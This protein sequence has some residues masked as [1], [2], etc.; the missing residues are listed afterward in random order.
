MSDFQVPGSV[1]IPD[2]DDCTFFVPREAKDHIPDN[3]GAR[4]FTVS[5]IIVSSGV[6]GGGPGRWEHRQ[7]T[8]NATCYGAGVEKFPSPVN[9]SWGLSSA[10]ARIIAAEL[11]RAA[12]GADRTV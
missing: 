9:L 11:V 2:P 4:G 1:P 10:T 7:V 12:D 8:L 6:S 3:C 5:E